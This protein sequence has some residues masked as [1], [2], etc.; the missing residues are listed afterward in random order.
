VSDNTINVT[1]SKVRKKLGRK[2]KL[3]T[4]VNEWYILEI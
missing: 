4:K 3:K 2:F 1:I